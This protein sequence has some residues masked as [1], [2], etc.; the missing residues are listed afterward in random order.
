MNDL[1]KKKINIKKSVK[2]LKRSSNRSNRSKSNSGSGNRKVSKKSKKVKGGR[3]SEEEDV[4]DEVVTSTKKSTKKTEKYNPVAQPIDYMNI[5]LN[6]F[7]LPIC[8]QTLL[9]PQFFRLETLGD[10]DC[11]YHAVLGTLNKD[12]NYNDYLLQDVNTKKKMA[13]AFRKCIGDDVANECGNN[14][15]YNDLN[16]SN[17]YFKELGKTP[18]LIE[19]LKTPGVWAQEDEVNAT[20]IYLGINIVCFQTITSNHNQINENDCYIYCLSKKTRP[21]DVSLKSIFIFNKDNLHY[22]SLLRKNDPQPNSASDKIVLKGCFN[23]SEK[24]VQKVYKE[25]QSECSLGSGGKGR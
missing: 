19:R 10:G 21:M 7:V 23:F 17:K 4:Y 20:A 1:I 18:D 22:E 9:S 24:C 25:Y 2:K 16:E 13:L 5:K 12:E 14:F 3:T 6:L 8:L 15:N 11:F